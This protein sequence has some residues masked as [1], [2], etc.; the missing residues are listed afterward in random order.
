MKKIIICLITISLMTNLSYANSNYEGYKSYI[1][2]LLALK[3]GDIETTVREYENVVL[4]DN[5]AI[6]VY[7]DLAL[8]YWQKGDGK[9]ALEI[10]K[11]A[12]DLDGETVKTNT[13][14]GT[15]YLS[16]NEMEL[17]K[18]CWEK[19]LEIDPKNET[20][21]VYLAAYY[22]SDNKLKESA[23]YWN[24]FLQDK[25]ESSEGY[26]QLGLVQEKLGLLDE[27]LKSY[28][29]VNELKPEAREAYLARARIYETKKEFKLAITEYEKYI[30]VFPDNISILLY[31][32]KCYFEEQRYDDAEK[33]LLKAKDIAPTNIP[34]HYLLGMTYEKQ[35][36]ID[37]AIEAFE[38]IVKNETNPQ[39][40]ARLGFYY[41]VKQDFKNAQMKFK[42]AIATEPLNAEFHYIY[43]LNFMD[44]KDYENASKELEKTLFLKSDFNDAKFYL[45]MAN[46]KL[47]NYDKTEELL[48]E[49]LASDPNDVKAMNYL[50]Y[51]YADRN[52]NLDE[53]EKLLIHVIE[54]A[55]NEPAFLDS[56]AW[57]YYRTG[58]Y[59]DA[60]KYMFM[61]INTEPKFF[62]KTLY[63]HLGDISVELNKL[64]Q[65]WLSYSIA[66]DMGSA[67]SKTKAKIVS[68]KISAKDMNKIAYERALHNFLRIISLK[69][70]YALKIQTP[71][72]KTNM[73]MSVLY[74]SGF[75]VKAN[76]PSKLTMPEFSVLFDKKE[77]VFSPKAI[78]ETMT[79][80][81]I[82]MFNFINFVFSKDFAQ[83]LSKSAVEEKGNTIIYSRDDI[84]VKINRKTGMLKELSK[85][86]LFILKI[87][88]YK[89][90]NKI[91]KVP[92]DIIF[93]SQ[94]TKF[95]CRIKLKKTVLPTSKDF[96]NFR[97]QD[98]TKSSGQ[99]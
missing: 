46:E 40:V 97:G 27:A 34:L 59:K 92:S 89:K 50:G 64:P 63:E 35:S 43:S 54:L 52:I 39:V 74:H 67:I 61:A 16:I 95:K 21:T 93:K 7:K 69:A 15:F 17:A 68:K 57:L 77:V 13:F 24:K 86:D 6:S 19:I 12:Q 81:I 18:K 71:V 25:P 22:Y 28:N 10:A 75:G 73:Y 26:F 49:I 11:K 48:K 83:M 4:H 30:T 37:G 96:E 47:G 58:K 94:K 84:T 88:S 87:S 9:K 36:N 53:A 33:I 98:D 80:E 65:A 91:S 66:E 78:E 56:L 2:G 1:G 41:A 44:M 42:Q 76:F 31:L 20:A 3:K 5:T 29:K 51:F 62:D 32:G 85:K 82:E 60:E 70:G 99:D 45:A 38:F 90:F 79:P 55:P 23:D 8:I 72:I 14:L